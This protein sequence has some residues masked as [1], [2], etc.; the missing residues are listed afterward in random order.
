MPDEYPFSRT[1]NGIR[2]EV[3]GD[4]FVIAEG[5]M[6]LGHIEDCERFAAMVFDLFELAPES[7]TD[8]LSD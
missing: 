1:I 6:E 8:L 4:G 5:A 7:D 2:F 3:D